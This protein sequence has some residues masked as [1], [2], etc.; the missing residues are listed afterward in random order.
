[1][2]DA[3]TA[4]VDEL[5]DNGLEDKLFGVLEG[6]LAYPDSLRQWDASAVDRPVSAVS[7]GCQR[8]LGCRGLSTK[9]VQEML[10]RYHVQQLTI[11][12]MQAFSPRMC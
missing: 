3:V 4:K 5:M 9:T 8:L 2:Q 10:V 12:L 1:M 11:A 6:Q 7:A